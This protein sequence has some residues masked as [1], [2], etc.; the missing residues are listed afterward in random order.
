MN[1][2]PKGKIILSL[3]SKNNIL[4]LKPAI[5]HNRLQLNIE[6]RHISR[7]S[8]VSVKVISII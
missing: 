6:S 4:H 3:K 2:I 1:D 7:I 5:Q 8:I